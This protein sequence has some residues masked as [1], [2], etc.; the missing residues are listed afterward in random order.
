MSFNGKEIDYDTIIKKARDYYNSKD[1]D[2]SKRILDFLIEK[3]PNDPRGFHDMARLLIILSPKNNYKESD[4]YYN[5]AISKA[6]NDKYTNKFILTK[7]KK[8]K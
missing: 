4:K 8:K 5:L 1:F 3:Y 2:K 6:M 7:K